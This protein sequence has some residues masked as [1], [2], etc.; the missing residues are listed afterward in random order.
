[1]ISRRPSSRR[2]SGAPQNDDLPDVGAL[3][4]ANPEVAEAFDEGTTVRLGDIADVDE[5]LVADV[6]GWSI[7]GAAEL[8]EPQ[9]AAEAAPDR[10]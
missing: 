8:G 5:E 10:R 6:N 3:L 1:M 7:I 2:R 4:E 9:T